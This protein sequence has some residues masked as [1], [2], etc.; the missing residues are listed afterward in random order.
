MIRIVELTNIVNTPP[1]QPYANL[2]GNLDHQ[3][4][5]FNSILVALGHNAV[6]ASPRTAKPCCFLFDQHLI[7]PILGLEDVLIPLLHSL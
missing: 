4:Q 3:F 1:G 6:Y 5:L 7:A 2:G